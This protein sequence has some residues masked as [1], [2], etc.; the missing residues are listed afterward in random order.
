M[1][2]GI[3]LFFCAM[4]WDEYIY[5]DVEWCEIGVVRERDDVFKSGMEDPRIPGP[6]PIFP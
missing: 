1:F 3:F 6:P 4:T 2:A 5:H